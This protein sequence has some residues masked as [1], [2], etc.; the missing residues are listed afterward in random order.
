MNG[1]FYQLLGWPKASSGPLLGSHTHLMLVIALLS[2]L[3]HKSLEPTRL[4]PKGL[5][6]SLHQRMRIFE[7]NL[8]SFFNVFSGNKQLLRVVNS[9][10]ELCFHASV[11][12]FFLI[13]L[14]LV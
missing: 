9:C 5:R 12:G 3:T 6:H 8:F 7:I 11:I 4:V 1:F 13:C 2:D 14:V 10:F